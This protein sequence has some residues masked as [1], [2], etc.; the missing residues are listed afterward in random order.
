MLVHLFGALGC[1][2]CLTCSVASSINHF[3]EPSQRKNDE[4]ISLASYSGN[5]NIVRDGDFDDNK[6]LYVYAVPLTLTGSELNVL[7]DESNDTNTFNRPL[8][9][10]GY[11]YAQFDFPQETSYFDLVDDYLRYYNF[12]LN[13]YNNN[14]YTFIDNDFVVWFL[15]Q[16]YSTNYQVF[17]FVSYSDEY[18][19]ANYLEYYQQVPRLLPS[20]ELDKVNHSDNFHSLDNPTNTTWSDPAYSF[21]TFQRERY[22][23]SKVFV[24]EF[25]N[26]ALMGN[27]FDPFDITFNVSLDIFFYQNADYLNGLNEGYN[28]GYDV[29][30]NSGYGT[31]Y[32]DGYN[33]GYQTGY[34][35][36]HA[37]GINE[38]TPLQMNFLTLLGAIADTPVVIIRNLYS[39]DIFGTSALAIFM[40]L[41]TAIIV[42]HFVRKFI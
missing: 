1:A 27:L 20:F 8:F 34:T 39:F 41:L 29:G 9:V 6:D 13:L 40:T 30:Y 5:V 26:S 31:G 2:L 36:G 3:D 21:L 16:K 24:K 11:N 10:G 23:F 38:A 14:I 15:V 33:Y 37:D 22:N 7:N 19:N 35:Q 4:S 42:I 12:V 28:K 18:A 25:Y 17:R 32:N